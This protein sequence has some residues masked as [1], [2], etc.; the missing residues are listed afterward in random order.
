MKSRALAAILVGVALVAA[1]VV[2]GFLA[3]DTSV[4]E[5]AARCY[6]QVASGLARVI[7]IFRQATLA[8]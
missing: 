7:A 2:Y 1:L 6:E 4:A 5:A 8:P 3:W